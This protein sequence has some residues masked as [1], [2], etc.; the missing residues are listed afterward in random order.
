MMEG[1]TMTA[2]DGLLMI[3]GFALGCLPAIEW[4]VPRARQSRRPLAPSPWI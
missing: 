1:G 3:V 4:L 2:L